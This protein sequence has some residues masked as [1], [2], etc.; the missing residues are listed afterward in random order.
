MRGMLLVLRARFCFP[1][2]EESQ[3]LDFGAAMLNVAFSEWTV[4]SHMISQV[5]LCDP[6]IGRQ[7][8]SPD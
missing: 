5:N 4:I 2:L 6:F 8:R 3:H 7:E 1:A